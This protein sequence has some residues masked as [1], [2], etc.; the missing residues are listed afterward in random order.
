[1][2][3]HNKTLREIVKEQIRIALEEKE[4]K[5]I[6]EGIDVDII[7]KT[8]SFNPNHENNVDTSISLNP[9]YDNING[10]DVIS[11][12]KRKMS[13]TSG[14]GDGNPLVYALKGYNDWK[15]K[16]PE[17][18]ISG[19][20]RNFIRISEKIQP[21]YDTII[22]VPSNNT[23]NINF[24]GR[25]NKILKAQY[26]ITD[27]LS[28]LTCEDVYENY[29]DWSQ[30]GVDFAEKDY[31]K[32]EKEIN[33]YFYEMVN[34]NNGFFSF[35]YFKNLALRKYITKTMYGS[36]EDVI[37]YAPIIN[38]KNVLILDDTIASGTSVSETCKD[39]INTFDPKNITII[40]LFSK[41]S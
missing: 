5:Y 23:L 29:I 34:K 17:K 24:L 25:L 21:I 33:K 15:F 26:K 22:T 41:L 18:D 4:D 16:N 27:Y 8:V 35:K 1:M 30:I 13:P 39:I 14:I 12:F 2:E 32:I 6:I 3:K 28:K 40:T 20:L 37:K 38:G 19:L 31:D 10:I 11:I 7:R 9:T 36:D